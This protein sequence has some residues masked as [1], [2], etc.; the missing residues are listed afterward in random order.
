MWGILDG[1]QH[2]HEHGGVLTTLHIH[3]ARTYV[4]T[5][6]TPTTHGWG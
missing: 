6:D 5:Q 2:L 4:S 3:V 1:C